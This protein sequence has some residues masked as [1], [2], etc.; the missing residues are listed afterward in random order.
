MLA[1]SGSAWSANQF[2]FNPFAA[3]LGIAGNSFTADTLTLADNAT[4]SID[5]AGNAT[6]SGIFTISSTQ[7]AGQT[8]NPLGLN[9]TAGLASS[10][11]L[12]GT[13]T[14]T[15]TGTF[16]NTNLTSFNYVL[17]G[18][19]THN[20]TFT[21][22]GGISGGAIGDIQLAHGT[23]IPPGSG[24]VVGPPFN[25]ALQVSNTFEVDFPAFFVNPNPFYFIIN[26]SFTAFGGQLANSGVCPPA[27]A[28]DVCT[29]EITSG[30]GTASFLAVPEP[31][32][33]ALLGIGLIGIGA[34]QR[35]KVVTTS[36]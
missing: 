12:Y 18:D 16:G 10:Y 14:A 29:F 21:N 22:G 27:A 11:G 6:E 5:F 8:F 35:R 17:W 23:Y 15:G 13:F 3:G 34:T 26:S 4:L 30:G 1:G 31:E 19:P 2:T 25:L 9:G 28:G 33:L 20:T 7:L 36:I 24:Q 32:T